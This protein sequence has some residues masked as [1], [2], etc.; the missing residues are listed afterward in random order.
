VPV[1]QDTDIAMPMR[2]R[3]WRDNRVCNLN[4]SSGLKSRDGGGSLIVEGTRDICPATETT[5]M[6]ES[7]SLVDGMVIEVACE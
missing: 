5:A 4:S 1:N 7:V 6:L 2:K 3:C